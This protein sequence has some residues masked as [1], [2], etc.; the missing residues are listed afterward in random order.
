MATVALYGPGDRRATRVAVG[1]LKAEGAEADPLE[2]WASEEVDVRSDAGIARQIIEFIEA[3][4]TKSVVL[5]DGIIGC[6]H[7][8][9]ID[10]PEGAVCPRCPFW[11]HRDR[12]T[13]E[14]HT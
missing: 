14:L 1:I 9:G 7:E 12:W 8:E 13:G 2:R 3:H 5:S 4:G 10:Y 11:A 6:P